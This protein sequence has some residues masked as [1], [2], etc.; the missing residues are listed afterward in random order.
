MPIFK[1]KSERARLE[2]HRRMSGHVVPLTLWV[3]TLCFG[4]L[5]W[6]RTGAGGKG[7]DILFVAAW[8]I[9]VLLLDIALRP[10]VKLSVASTARWQGVSPDDLAPA[11]GVRGF[12]GLTGKEPW[13]VTWSIL[14][15]WVSLPVL[16]VLLGAGMLLRDHLAPERFPSFLGAAVAVGI[17]VAFLLAPV[18]K[19]ASGEPARDAASGAGEREPA[20]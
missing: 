14:A 17:L 7:S 4:I 11:P 8:A 15:C 6:A 9:P 16:L 13:W 3:F 18:V 10:L 12:F 19:A 20:A 5:D 2:G 1:W